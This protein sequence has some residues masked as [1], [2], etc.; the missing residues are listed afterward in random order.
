MEKTNKTIK[1][2]IE[3]KDPIEKQATDLNKHNTKEDTQ[4]ASKHMRRYCM[5]QI[6]RKQKV[7]TLRY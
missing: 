5:P 1:L 3:T 4:T 6:I 7:T 2:K